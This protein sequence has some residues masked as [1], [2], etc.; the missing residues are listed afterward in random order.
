[1]ITDTMRIPNGVCV[2]VCVCVCV[3]VCVKN[4]VLVL[5]NKLGSFSQ[6]VSSSKVDIL[7]QTFCV[8][9]IHKSNK[10]RK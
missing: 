4:T 2:R 7:S 5:C 8:L 10:L 9:A 6:E 3:C 1:M